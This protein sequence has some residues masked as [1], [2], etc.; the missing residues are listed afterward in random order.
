MD[1]PRSTNKLLQNIPQ[2]R[3]EI[4][5]DV[6]FQSVEDSNQLS[7]GTEVSPGSLHTLETKWYRRIHEISR[8]QLSIQLAEAVQK[9]LYIIRGIV[10][11]IRP[12]NLIR[13]V[14]NNFLLH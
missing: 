11:M 7:Q 3:T 12:N 5:V 6:V 1:L 10:Q 9:L 2:E 13:V 8:T 14:I 4:C